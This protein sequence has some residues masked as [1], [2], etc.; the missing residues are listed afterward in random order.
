[1]GYLIEELNISSCWPKLVL[2][3]TDDINLSIIIEIHL[4]GVQLTMNLRPSK[5]WEKFRSGCRKKLLAFSEGS[6]GNNGERLQKCC[7]S[8]GKMYEF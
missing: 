6:V 8:N 2:S 1:V 5:E 3:V 7:P 4:L